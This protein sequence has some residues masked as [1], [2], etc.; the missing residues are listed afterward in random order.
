MPRLRRS[1]S[2][3]LINVDAELV[4]FRDGLKESYRGNRFAVSAF[5]KGREDGYY[6]VNDRLNERLSEIRRNRKAQGILALDEG[7]LHMMMAHFR[8]AVLFN[9]C[10]L[11][12]N[13]ISMKL[14]AFIQDR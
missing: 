12:F 13:C 11:A 14:T 10:K 8:N 2:A 9:V 7:M 6:I 4:Q 1:D 5:K 3:P